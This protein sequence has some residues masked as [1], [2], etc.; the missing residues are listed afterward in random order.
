VSLSPS[1]M[2]AVVSLHQIDMLTGESLGSIDSVGWATHL[3]ARLPS[4]VTIG[5]SAAKMF[6][7]ADD[8]E[9][10]NP[11][12]APLDNMD[13]EDEYN[14]DPGPVELE[15][16]RG[17]KRKAKDSC[18]SLA[19]S[20]SS[21]WLAILNEYAHHF[22]K[23]V[24]ACCTDSSL[25]PDELLALWK[26]C[27]NMISDLRNIRPSNWRSNE[28]K[29]CFINS[30]FT[31][32]FWKLEFIHIHPQ[33]L[34]PLILLPLWRQC[35]IFDSICILLFL[36]FEEEI[37]SL[38]HI[39]S[40][41]HFPNA[42]LLPVPIFPDQNREFAYYYG[43]N[44]GRDLASILL[45]F[46]SVIPLE[47]NPSSIFFLSSLENFTEAYADWLQAGLILRGIKVSL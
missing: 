40:P 27:Q 11:F 15:K 44:V 12:A 31:S 4:S 38:L 18:P 8:L 45:D 19:H 43:T 35:Q 2:A 14:K 47:T 9:A 32:A 10:N 23:L 22:D 1:T 6:S 24:L 29:A 28:W 7:H 17:K 42:R 13:S 39:N 36:W 33:Y 16:S 5:D 37:C 21:K 30:N 25:S 3:A 34:I 46:P 20:Q 41:K 26:Y